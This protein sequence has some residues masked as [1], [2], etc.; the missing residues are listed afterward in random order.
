MLGKIYI[1]RSRPWQGGARQGREVVKQLTINNEQPTAAAAAT[2]A[3][4]TAAAATTA[5][6]A[7]ANF[8]R[9]N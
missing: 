2:A 9:R 7:A 1:R 5:A 3:A 4:A 8:W 6:A